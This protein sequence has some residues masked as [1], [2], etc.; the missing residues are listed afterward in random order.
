M[1]KYIRTPQVDIKRTRKVINK[2]TEVTSIE[3]S[4][5]S[6]LLRELD[7]MLE[8]NISVT[9]TR[10][11]KETNIKG[12]SFKTYSAIF[13]D[14]IDMLR[15]FV[16]GTKEKTEELASVP[17]FDRLEEETAKLIQ[18]HASR[19]DYLGNLYIELENLNPEI[20]INDKLDKLY[21]ILDAYWAF[22]YT[23]SYIHQDFVGVNIFDDIDKKIENTYQY[24]QKLWK[25]YQELKTEL[26]HN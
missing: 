18:Q 16:L 22:R 15:M 11:A 2:E 5:Q 7:D 17:D 1:A 12:G 21:D 9:K 25:R 3:E 24:N 20:D 8:N 13:D 26:N 23:T 4:L 6:R 14:T 19:I 10:L